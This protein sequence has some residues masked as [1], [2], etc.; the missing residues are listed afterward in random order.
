MKIQIETQ[1]GNIIELRDVPQDVELVTVR[2]EDG[3]KRLV[4]LTVDKKDLFAAVKAFC[5]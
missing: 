3:G 5:R 1:G 2:I 4:T